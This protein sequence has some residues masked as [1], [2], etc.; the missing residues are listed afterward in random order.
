[1]TQILLDQQEIWALIGRNDRPFSEWKILQTST[2]H[3][4]LYT[5]YSKARVQYKRLREYYD[6]DHLKIVKFSLDN[7]YL[8][9]VQASMKKGEA[10]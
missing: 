8:D 1:M 6:K 5:S 2:R 10:R 9:R 4:M 7:D 3:A